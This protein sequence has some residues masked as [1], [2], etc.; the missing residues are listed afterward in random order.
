[1]PI[2]QDGWQRVKKA[3]SVFRGKETSETNDYIPYGVF[4][5]TMVPR[6]RPS[7]FTK[8]D[9]ALITTIQNKIANDAAQIKMIQC[10]VDEDE[11]YEEAVTSGLNNVLN[12]DA[13]LDQSGYDFKI[14]AFMTLFKEGV[15]ALVPYKTDVPMLTNNE[16]D[17][18]EMRVGIIQQ[19]YPKEVLI[20]LWNDD[21]GRRM[22][23]RLPKSKVAIVT[24]PFYEVMNEPNSL[25]Q[26]LSSKYK[27]LDMIDQKLGS[28]KLD[29]I[30]QLP[31]PLKGP[32][33]ME[34]AKMRQEE[35]DRQLSD[36]KYGVAYIDGNEK[37][38]QLNR[39]LENNLLNQIEYMEKSL[40]TQMG[41]TPEILNG[42]ASSEVMTNYYNRIVEPVVTVVADEITRKFVRLRNKEG[43]PVH[44]DQK[45][46]TFRDP[47]KLVPVEKIAEIADKFTRNEIA[48]S[49]EMRA[50]VGWKPVDDPKADELRNAN[51]NHP[52]EQQYEEPTNA[53]DDMM[54]YNLGGDQDGI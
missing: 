44:A 15:V 25:V 22:N 3:W 53:P 48:T 41:I 49:N 37:I 47:F 33:R 14:D 20:S 12:F 54:Y 31:F 11:R 16:F 38:V 27:V 32:A 50:V 2:V 45:I 24:N 6:S 34:Q 1:M 30:I 51:L 18:Y 4:G 17:I 23:V 29:L 10:K 52:D 21:V 7:A 36:T 39:P 40:Y 19:W 42:T 46:L 28:S 13:N 26:R 9:K 5:S 8:N 35:I 43:R